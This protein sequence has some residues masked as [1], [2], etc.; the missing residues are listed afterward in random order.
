MQMM[1]SSQMLRE[2]LCDILCGIAKDDSRLVVLDSDLMNSSGMKKFAEKFPERFIN[3]G[4]QEANM[5]G[6]A[7]GFSLEGFIPVTHSFASF[8]GRRAVDQVFMA[9]C[10]NRQNIKMIGSDPGLIN[11]PNG[12]T[13]MGLE[14]I[15]IMRSITGI[16]ILDITDEVMLRQI[17]PE[18]IRTDGMFYIR[19]FRKTKQKIYSGD[20]LF[21]IGKGKVVIPGKD[22]TIIAE[23]PVM[24]SEAM[25]AADILKEKGIQARVVDMFTIQP[26]DSELIIS[27]A[28][29]T[30]AILTVE[31]H[32]RRGGLGSAVS[33]V[34]A[35][36]GIGVPFVR[37]G[38]PEKFGITGT[39]DYTLKTFGLDSFAIVKH[40][41]Q[42][43]G[44]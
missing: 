38:F 33:E 7:G 5:I 11:C 6:V 40:A 25:K 26:I 14:D 18:I 31:N 15:G 4:I 16:V 37:M 30:K 19:I 39:L 1:N 28:Q 10:Y 32:N 3:T 24:V 22:I 9:G 2:V 36:N 43:L 17:L 23:G 27:S 35:E 34:L 41:E 12:G 20:E 13:H 44:V 8:A 42:L 29:E 21:S